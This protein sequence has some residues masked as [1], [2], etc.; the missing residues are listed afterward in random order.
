M[1]ARALTHNLAGLGHEV[2][3]FPRRK[4]D[5]EDI[6]LWIRPPHYVK[7]KPFRRKGVINV[8]YT[9]HE[10]ETFTGWK[11]NWPRLLNWCHAIITPTEW[12]KQV[13]LDNG[14]TSPIHVVPLGVNAKDFHGRRSYEFSILTVHDAL[15]SKSSRENWLDTLTAY[16][17]AFYGQEQYA[18]DVL[19]T[20]KSWNVRNAEF[21]RALNG[22]R[23]VQDVDLLPSVRVV[24]LDLPVHAM[25]DLYGRHWLFVKNANREGW[26]L[27]LWEALAADCRVAYTDLPLWRGLVPERYGHSFP[28]GDVDALTEIMLDEFRHWKKKKGWINSFSWNMCAKKVE[29]VLYGV[30]GI[31]NRGGGQPAEG[32]E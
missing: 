15:G 27:P 32:K 19:L 17:R 21:E 9:M 29:E 30:L 26:G 10:T 14:V 24:E 25:N 23:D 12:N 1:I 7:Y 8:F 13:F 20:I 3:S 2:C 4:H 5:T 11:A 16:H 31:G 6:A 22:L 28:L 18:H